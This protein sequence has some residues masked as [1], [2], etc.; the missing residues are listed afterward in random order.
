MKRSRRQNGFY[1]A[2]SARQDISQR[3]VF[4]NFNSGCILQINY[5]Q[6]EF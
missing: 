1:T 5:R 4:N 2:L 3:S 6:S